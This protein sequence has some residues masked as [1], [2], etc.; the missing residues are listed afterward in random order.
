MLSKALGREKNGPVDLVEKSS[1]ADYS[2]LDSDDRKDRRCDSLT[3]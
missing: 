1:S 3:R 2:L